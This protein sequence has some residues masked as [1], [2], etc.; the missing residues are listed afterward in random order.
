[1][2]L[3]PLNYDIPMRHVTLSDLNP[4]IIGKNSI[5]PSREHQIYFHS[6]FHQLL[7]KYLAKN[8]QAKLIILGESNS[9]GLFG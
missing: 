7:F 5:Y 9:G 4:L 3:N 2:S 1:L 6:S 8:F